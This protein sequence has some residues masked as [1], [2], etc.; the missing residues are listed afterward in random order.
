[1]E[2]NFGLSCVI[3]EGCSLP[4]LDLSG[5]IFPLSPAPV[6]F[7]M[8]TNIHESHKRHMHELW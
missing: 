6:G 7:L 2:L 1:M 8:D 5:E 3:I 4:A